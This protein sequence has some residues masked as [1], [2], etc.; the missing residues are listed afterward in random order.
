VPLGLAG[1][2]TPENVAQAVEASGAVAVDAASGVE[3]SPGRKDAGR[4]R[5]FVSAAR[6]ALGSHAGS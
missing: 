3:S 1:G 6:V 4:V 2:L 5:A